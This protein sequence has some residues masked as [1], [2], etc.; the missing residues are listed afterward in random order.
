MKICAANLR[1]PSD[2]LA[3]F[4]ELQEARETAINKRRK[5]IER[6]IQQIRDEYKFVEQDMGAYQRMSTK[7][8]EIA[9]LQ[10][11]LRATNSHIKSGVGAVMNLLKDEGLV[12]GDFADETTL[13]LTVRGKLASQLRET[14]SLIFSKLLDDRILDNLSARQ[15][16][17]VL[18]VFANI[19]VEDDL[20]D[21][22][23]KAEDAAVQ[24]MATM[25]TDLYAEYRDKEHQYRI[26]T[27]FDYNIQYDLIN[28]VNEW[29]GCEDVDSCKFL[30]QKMGEER[31]IFLGEFVKALLKINNISCELEKLAELTG[32]IAFLNK[33]KEIPAMTMKYVVTNQSLYV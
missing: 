4:I 3:Q 31:H 13:K 2:V 25:L 30:L 23:P 12:E 14:H 22:C 27:G 15:L 1:T 26:N 7:E 33:L 8:S 9:D 24:K 32:N 19:S 20:R 6:N 11:Q 10:S 29:C 28:Y 5:E 17:S 18:S 16:V 21:G